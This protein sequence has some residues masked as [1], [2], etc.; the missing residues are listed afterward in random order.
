M[1]LKQFKTDGLAHFSYL[2]GAGNNAAVIDPQ[3]DVELYLAAAQAA[4][5]QIR[6]I[7]ET[8]RNEDF[9]S[10]A[11]HLARL[12]GAEVYHGPNPAGPVQYA[13]TVTEG[14]SVDVGQLT[15]KVLETPG[16]TDDSICI[17]IFD[18][19]YPDGAVGVFTG[20]ALFIGDVGR[21]DF[22]PHRAE[23]VAGLLFDS[24]QKLL[25]LGDQTILYPAH[26]AG[27][28]CGSGMAEREFSTL[29]HERSNNPRLQI[30]DR[31]AFISAKLKETHYQPP[32]F[33]LMERL[34]LDGGTPGPSVSQIPAASLNALQPPETDIL[35]DVRPIEAHLARHIPGS[36]LLPVDMIAAFGG[37]F[38]EED[39]RIGLVSQ[40]ADAA[41]E[42]VKH[43]NRI[44][45]QKIEGFTTGL[46]GKA[47]SGTETDL[48]ATADTNAVASRLAVSTE[49]WT[50][51]DVRS[52]EEFESGHIEGAEHVY[53]GDVLK[54]PARYLS[55][56]G[57][58]VMCGSG[59]RASLAASALK[60]AGQKGLDVYVGSIGAWRA[61]D[62]PVT[63]DD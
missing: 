7:F 6:H 24:L 19:A 16:H 55:D 53:V 30:S 9:I 51:L 59:A 20:D 52:I 13:Q 63:S 1:L 3:L 60:A 25:G 62:K 38:L 42:A 18:T 5:L 31:D 34:N 35:L 36:R 57:I 21:T 56:N 47:A 40:T 17:A 8:H 45:F 4:G 26:G 46:L 50:L 29:G 49:N 44:G 23:E 12:T 22:Y 27:S 61:A 32:Y 58:T 10:G 39:M 41:R 2:I 43:L 14:F 54:D 33:K 28:V 11:A 15:L 48:I 37:W